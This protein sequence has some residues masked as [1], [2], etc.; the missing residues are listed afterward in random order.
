[1]QLCAPIDWLLN[2]LISQMP[3]FKLF[4]FYFLIYFNKYIF[5]FCIFLS[6]FPSQ[7]TPKPRYVPPWSNEPN[8]CFDMVEKCAKS[9]WFIILNK[10]SIYHVYTQTI[11]HKQQLVTR[12][13]CL[14]EGVK[15]KKTKSFQEFQGRCSPVDDFNLHLPIYLY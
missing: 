3:R 15:Y 5:D 6:R 4:I 7:N 11:A 13:F 10:T 2:V 1:M 14:R 12:L 8:T 9:L